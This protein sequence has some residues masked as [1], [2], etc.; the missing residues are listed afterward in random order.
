MNMKDSGFLGAPS[1]NGPKGQA[2]PEVN[3][4]GIKAMI[5]KEFKE[6][7]ETYIVPQIAETLKASL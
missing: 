4:T 5:H 7:M 3:E 2:Q 1:H 6:A